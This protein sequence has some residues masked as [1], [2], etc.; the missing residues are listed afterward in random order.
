[1]VELNENEQAIV[2]IMK[3]MGA[4]T[5]EKS[6]SAEDIA[7]KANMAKPNAS[8]IL[9]SLVAK[10]VAKKMVGHKSGSYYLLES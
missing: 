2:E 7:K 9:V 4:T 1:M 6:K 5:Q 3:N 10:K 8:N